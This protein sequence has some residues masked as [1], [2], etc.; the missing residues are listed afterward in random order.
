MDFIK[1]N[2]ESAFQDLNKK[3]EKARREHEEE[4]RQLKIQLAQNKDRTMT[5]LQEAKSAIALRPATPQSEVCCLCLSAWP[6]KKK[7]QPLLDR[8]FSAGDVDPRVE[9]WMFMLKS[10]SAGT[11]LDSTMLQTLFKKYDADKDG[12]LS[13]LEVKPMLQEIARAKRQQLEHKSHMIAAKTQAQSAQDADV[14][15][16]VGSMFQGAIERELALLKKQESGDVDALNLNQIFSELDLD[17]DGQ[18]SLNVFLMKAKDTLFAKEW[19][20]VRMQHGTEAAMEE[21][22][23]Q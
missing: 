8:A 13:R 16:V 12:F 20:G 11:D 15:R 9:A 3:A 22:K 1:P 5:E 2:L 17:E 14:A 19:R 10:V 23:Q 6:K 4:Q 18:V 7:P 21:C